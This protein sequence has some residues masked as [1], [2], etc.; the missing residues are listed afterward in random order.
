MLPP[1]Q[2]PISGQET[3]NGV[4]NESLRLHPPVPGGVYRLSP[5]EGL[6]IGDHFIPGDINILTPTWTIQR[7]KQH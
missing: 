6:R 1:R 2:G 4:I 3:L 7:C 5:P